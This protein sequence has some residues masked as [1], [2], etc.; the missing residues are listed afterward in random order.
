MRDELAEQGPARR[1]AALV[2]SLVG[3]AVAEAAGDAE[4]L[5]LRLVAFQAGQ[6]GEQP[7]ITA[8]VGG[9]LVHA[10]GRR[11]AMVAGDA[12]RA[13]GQSTSLRRKRHTASPH[14]AT[15][16]SARAAKF[17]TSTRPQSSNTAC[18]T[19]WTQW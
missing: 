19:S 18:R 17:H 7:A 8:A 16:N 13:R 3:P 4:R 12:P 14:I 2:R 10:A 9:G 15:A 1:L 5:Q 6:L 11:Q